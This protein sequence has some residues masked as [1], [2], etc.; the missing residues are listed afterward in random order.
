VRTTIYTGEIRGGTW[1][2]LVATGFPRSAVGR[3]FGAH[4]HRDKCGPRPEDSGPHYQSPLVPSSAPLV[5]REVW[6]NFRV[7]PD[8]VGRSATVRP[9]PIP[10]GA[11][12]SVVIHSGRTDPR[13]GDAGDR[14][15]CTT[16]PF[17]DF[18]H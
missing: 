6:P 11:A 16:V 4:V 1:V 18:R 8:G 7:G 15:L 13:T 9:W 14:I 5:E 17:G 10:Q 3:T 12:G 2:V